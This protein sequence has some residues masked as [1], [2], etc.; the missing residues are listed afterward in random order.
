MTGSDDSPR[1]PGPASARD[2]APQGLRARAV[3][4]AVAAAAVP[5]DG[6]APADQ[7][8]TAGV[9]EAEHQAEL[10]D[11]GLRFTD[12][13]GIVLLLLVATYFVTAIGGDHTWGRSASLIL[14]AAT[15]WLTLR[16]S[17]VRRAGL[18]WGMTLIPIVTV[19]AVVATLLGDDETGRAVNAALTAV[20]VVVAPIV[21]VRRLASHLVVSLNTFYG[22]ICVY[23]LIAMFFA[24]AYALTAWANGTAF[25]AQIQPP[26]HAGTID[27]LYF[28]FITIT[29]VGYGDLT[30]AGSVGRMTAS[31]EAIF[32]QLYLITVVALVV[33]NLGQERRFKGLRD[34]RKK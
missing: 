5:G 18:R 14:L 22:A 4:A 6:T 9:A 29:T 8:L 34:R 24:S 23:L 28:S 26:A 32:G 13:Y 27:Y 33:Q 3:A 2:S 10:E 17:H 25:F 11:K 19:V 20:L 7:G 16:A 1:T 30:A 12:S 21:I 15:T 31:I